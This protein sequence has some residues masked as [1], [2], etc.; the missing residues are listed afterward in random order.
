MI[1]ELVRKEASGAI[2]AFSP[3]GLGVSSGHDM[4]HKGFYD[5]LM[6]D[7]ISELGLAS[8]NSKLW[9]YQ[10]G[11]NQDLLHTYTIFGDPALKIQI[12]KMIFI[13]LTTAK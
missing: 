13:P 10:T 7:G 4:L 1:E 3:T 6:N 9:L 11:M 8:Q 2:A 5:A 12:P